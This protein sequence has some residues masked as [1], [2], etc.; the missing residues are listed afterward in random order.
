MMA[1]A[2]LL[3]AMVAML[4]IAN[5]FGGSPMRPD[6]PELGGQSGGVS[7]AAGEMLCYNCSGLTTASLVESTPSPQ[8]TSQPLPGGSP[9]MAASSI[10]SEE[11]DAWF[12]R[13]KVR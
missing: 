2:T 5:I 6:S 12:W 1:R 8:S 7:L 11:E 3:L 13:G 9:I 4:A 10:E